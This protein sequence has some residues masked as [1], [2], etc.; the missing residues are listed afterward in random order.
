MTMTTRTTLSN[1]TPGQRRHTFEIGCCR[2]NK[3]VNMTVHNAD[4]CH[5]KEGMNVQVAF[6]YLS[7]KCHELLVSGICSECTDIALASANEESDR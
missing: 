4:F 3:K 5:W 2:C 6:P 7:A 1:A